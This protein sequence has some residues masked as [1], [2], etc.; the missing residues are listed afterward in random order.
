MRGNATRS[1]LEAR[2]HVHDSCGQSNASFEA[3]VLEA[4]PH[5]L[6]SCDQDINQ[7]G[8]CVRN[9]IL[10]Y[11]IA[12]GYLLVVDPDASETID[13]VGWNATSFFKSTDDN[14]LQCSQIPM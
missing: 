8:H 12:L 5:K 11:S 1:V 14:F 6:D 4:G 9:H 2:T 10:R 3:I 13:A 7:R